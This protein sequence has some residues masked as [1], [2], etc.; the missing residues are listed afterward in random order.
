MYLSRVRRCV[1]GSSV[2]SCSDTICFLCHLRFFA[3]STYGHFHTQTTIHTPDQRH[4]HIP[5]TLHNPPQQCPHIPTSHR[6]T[7]FPPASHPPHPPTPAACGHNLASLN[8][9]HLNIP[10]NAVHHCVPRE[11]LPPRSLPAR[12][13]PPPQAAGRERCVAVGDHAVPA[14]ARGDHG[15]GRVQ[16]W[17]TGV[18]G[19]SSVVCRHGGL[20]FAAGDEDRYGGAGG[21]A[22]R[23]TEFGDV[24]R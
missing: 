18:G 23:F 13:L 3:P 5:T 11:S 24:G 9:L 8:Y 12:A 16:R 15:G 7:S 22:C 4:I 6:A 17:R 2:T 1:S 20:D 19:A 21:V 14:G 10:G